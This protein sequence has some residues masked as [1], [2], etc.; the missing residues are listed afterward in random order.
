MELDLI[1]RLYGKGAGI[2]D[3]VFGP[4][5]DRGRQ[6]AVEAINASDARS[7]LEVGVG[8][9]L[10]LPLY[11]HDLRVT[12]IDL[13][14]EMLTKARE[15]ARGLEQVDALHEMD[16]QNLAFAD[17]SFDAA[18]AMYVAA[19]VPDMGRLFGELRRVCKPGGSIL[20]V[21][22]LAAESGVLGAFDRLMAPAS[23]AMAVRSDLKLKTLAETAGLAVEGVE[24]AGIGGYIK[25]VRFRNRPG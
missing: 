3:A 5:L 25:L 17:A 14:P 12:G 18:V 21:N 4:L 6:A 11:R 13:S 15:R 8:T 16:A 10:S 23:R 2:Y 9:G 22:H 1:R 19:V 24:D 20:V 7:V